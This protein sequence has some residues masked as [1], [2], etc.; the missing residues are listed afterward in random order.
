MVNFFFFFIKKK[1]KNN[2]I[3]SYLINNISNINNKM[4]YCYIINN[5]NLNIT[6]L[7]IYKIYINK[8]YQ[9]III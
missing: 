2:S 4:F 8:N 1:K 5:K 6:F 3:I 7:L 9:I